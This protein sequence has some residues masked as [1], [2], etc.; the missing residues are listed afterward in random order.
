[1]KFF[2]LAFVKPNGSGVHRKVLNQLN[3]IEDLFDDI[4]VVY[5]VDKN[6]FY[7]IATRYWILLKI[8]FNRTET[9]YY[10]RQQSFVPFLQL[11]LKNKFWVYELNAHVPSER[12]ALSFL[13]RQ[14][15]RF[16]S[17][18]RCI[19][20]SSFVVSVS[21]ELLELYDYLGCNALVVSNSIRDVPSAP[22]G[23]KTNAL[24]CEVHT[25]K[26]LKFLYVVNHAQ[27]WQG[28]DIFVKIALN[29][30]DCD[31]HVAGYAPPTLNAPNIHHH[32]FLDEKDL[33]TLA[34]TCD[35][36][37]SSLAFE[38]SGLTE[39]SPLKSRFYIEQDL[40]FVGSYRDTEFDDYPFY[41]RLTG[42]SEEI[43]DEF[44]RLKLCFTKCKPSDF[45]LS[46]HVY[47]EKELIKFRKIIGAFI[48]NSTN[49]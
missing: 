43:V 22:S 11:F 46:S 28:F 26:R 4:E 2:Y 24:D 34:G 37:I 41:T 35:I 39:A 47:R 25:S 29:S 31:F 18:E 10:V 20:K 27:S 14:I 33:I 23:K 15:L 44:E 32:G 40:P 7:K 48:E 12:K 16:S 3:S 38:R 21:N 45:D 19:F 1:M 6:Y 49:R 36:G 13:K 42:T 9:I 17:D 30:I 5:D 8:L